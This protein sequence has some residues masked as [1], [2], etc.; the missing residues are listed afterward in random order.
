MDFEWGLS[1][2]TLFN[3]KKIA[4]AGTE[5]GHDADPL[6]SPQ[7]DTAGPGLSGWTSEHL[8]RIS[9]SDS[10]IEGYEGL[11]PNKRKQSGYQGEGDQAVLGD[12]YTE[13]YNIANILTSS[14]QP[15][16]TKWGSDFGS[17]IDIMCNTKD[18]M[19]AHHHGWNGIGYFSK[20]FKKKVDELGG[21]SINIS[22]MSNW[23]RE[24]IAGVGR[25]FWVG[26]NLSLVRLGFKPWIHTPGIAG[27]SNTQNPSGS[28]VEWMGDCTYLIAT[29]SVGGD[30]C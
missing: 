27:L 15:W 5:I 12:N 8:K 22:A 28:Y 25:G 7:W 24:W 19:A 23:G 11:Y 1:K 29:R 14:L 17:R 3:E 4:V 20:R 9:A 13:K 18:Y 21:P 10:P 6:A 26:D 2:G 16:D 30:D